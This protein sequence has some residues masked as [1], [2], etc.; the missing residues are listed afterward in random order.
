MGTDKKSKP[1]LRRMVSTR[2]IVVKNTETQKWIS[3]P[4]DTELVGVTNSDGQISAD[5]YKTLNWGYG[6]TAVAFN[7]RTPEGL[8]VFIPSTNFGGLTTIENA[9]AAYEAIMYGDDNDAEGAS[10]TVLFSS[11]DDQV[12]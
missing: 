6:W 5:T 7:K 10:A 8:P 2:S 11:E 4:V 9:E 1:T 3:I 12:C